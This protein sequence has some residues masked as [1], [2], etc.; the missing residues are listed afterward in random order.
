MKPITAFIAVAAAV[1]SSG[2]IAAAE[3]PQFTPGQSYPWE[4][5]ELMPGDQ[6]AWVYLL[7][8]KKGRATDCRIGETNIRGSDAR[9]ILCM[10]FVKNWYTK[11]ILND[12]GEPVEGWFKRYFL[13]IGVKHQ[14][15]DLEARKLYF[16]QHPEV[17]P[18]CYPEYTR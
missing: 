18:E 7:I 1:A 12:A 5:H 6:Y 15:R 3:C 14:S 17:R 4:S 8:D 2:A 10:S 11:P 16:Q 9:G 13:E